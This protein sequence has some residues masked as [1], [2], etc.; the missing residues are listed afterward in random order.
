MNKAS[1]TL[2]GGV[3]IGIVLTTIINLTLMKTPGG[4]VTDSMEVSK[5]DK[6]EPLYWVAPMDPNYR[7]DKPGKSPMGMDLIPFYADE[8]GG[9][10]AGPGTIRIS[11]DVVNNLGVRTA[12]AQMKSLHSEITT[13]GYVQYDEDQLVH[14]HPRVEGWIEKLN[15]KT[16][17]EKVEEGQVLYEIYSPALVN[18]QE[19]LVLALSRKNQR[20]ID[21][22]KDRLE[23]LQL[24]K[25]AIK[26]L[27]KSRKVQQNIAFYAPQSG[28]VDNLNIRQ[29]YFVKPGTT[30]MSIAKLD[31]V[32]VEAEVFERQAAQV[33]KGMAVS[34]MLDFLPGKTWR[35]NV[36]YIYPKLDNKTRTLRVRLRF[37]NSD[38]ALKPNMFAQI[39]IHVQNMEPLLLVPKSAVIRSG[40]SNRVVLALGEGK[41]KSIEV[42][43]GRIDDENIEILAGLDEGEEV[44]TSAQFL[45]DSESSKTSDFIRMD[46]QLETESDELPMATTT[47]VI[48]SLMKEHG[49]LNIS[50]DAIEEWGR[51]PATLDFIADK[52]VDISNLNIGDKIY[53]TF[54][55]Q[56]GQFIVTEIQ[57]LASFDE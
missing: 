40:Q 20:L 51:G 53:F 13:V 6:K 9:V 55:V 24:P 56:E 52:S 57:P 34:M 21:A 25:E 3:I 16:T 37:D 48:N 39:V 29:G 36:D 30:I 38:L 11:P 49:M 22:A 8:G 43:V 28:F 2:I 35:G 10:D 54:K 27:M 17:G 15:V 26:K 19:E 31:Q 14:I 32:W 33:Y 41:F 7:R 42:K 12:R 44:V 23:A 1:L 46:H 4:T 5:P 18:A 50:R 45:L 47:G